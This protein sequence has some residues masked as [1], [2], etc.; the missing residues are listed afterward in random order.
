M[1]NLNG[2]AAF[3]TGSSQGV[4]L[5]LAE[6]FAEHGADVVLHDR[7]G[8]GTEH[9]AMAKI[10]TRGRKSGFV[11]A[12]LLGDPEPTA[13]RVARE[14]LAIHP[15]IDIVVNSAG[16]ALFDVPYEQMT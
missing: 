6:A 5:A 12:D 2:H 8:G 14:A 9:E 11:A 15:K 13:D 3:I 7:A 4:G 1:I 16:G 10:T